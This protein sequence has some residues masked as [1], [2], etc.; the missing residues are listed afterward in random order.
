VVDV[1]VLAAPPCDPIRSKRHNGRRL[2]ALHT[3]S[4]T[5]T[6]PPRSSKVRL[7]GRWDQQHD[8]VVLMVESICGQGFAYA[9]EVEERRQKVVKLRQEKTTSETTGSA[10][11]DQKSAHP[12]CPPGAFIDARA[13]FSKK[14]NLLS[15]SLAGNRRHQIDLI[16]WRVRRCW[17]PAPQRIE[18]HPGRAASGAWPR[19]VMWERAAQ[20]A[21]EWPRRIA[22]GR[23]ISDPPSIEQGPDQSTFDRPAHMRSRERTRPAGG[24]RP[25]GPREPSRPSQ[26]DLTGLALE[27]QIA[28]AARGAGQR[29][30][31]AQPVR[32]QRLFFFFSFCLFLFLFA[33]CLDGATK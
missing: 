26:N 29:G 33:V 13:G 16:T 1:V 6:P 30:R 21:S 19:A 11:T 27:R 2:R 22:A 5:M 8:G 20:Q 32:L 12:V 17:Q 31:P 4:A 15:T 14:P 10:A 23:P 24:S 28:L 25:G 9:H 18:T 7:C 3:Y